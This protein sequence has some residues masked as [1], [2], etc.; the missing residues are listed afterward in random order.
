MAPLTIQS[1]FAG[2]CKAGCGAEW[3]SGAVLFGIQTQATKADGSYVLRWCTNQSCGP[4]Q[5]GNAPAMPQQQQAATTQQQQQQTTPGLQLP[6]IPDAPE[7]ITKKIKA[8]ALE[9][10]QVRKHVC[11]V[12][13]QYEE[14]PN[15]AMIGQMVGLI[16]QH[17]KYHAKNNTNTPAEVPNQ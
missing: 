2:K 4:I 12:V 1:K 6:D 11:Q 15:P 9:I 16:W 7:H 13:N 10:M 14:N 8:S 3:A 17:C 5:D